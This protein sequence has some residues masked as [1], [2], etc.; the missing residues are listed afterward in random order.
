MPYLVLAYMSC[1]GGC[2][3]EVPLASLFQALFC[4]DSCRRVFLPTTSSTCAS[5]GRSSKSV[6][7]RFP[8]PI[9]NESTPFAP[10]SGLGM[11]RRSDSGAG[12]TQRRTAQHHLHAARAGARR[13]CDWR[14]D[15]TR[16]RHGEEA[17]VD[18]GGPVMLPLLA[19]SLN[20]ASSPD[21]GF[22]GLRRARPWIRRSQ[23]VSEAVNQRAARP[24]QGDDRHRQGRTNAR[25]LSPSL[26]RHFAYGHGRKKT[27]A[28]EARMSPQP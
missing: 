7:K 5:N 22:C 21:A 27:G 13:N 19:E 28:V 17:L 26:A 24:N 25:G 3:H 23:L 16:T 12:G 9:R 4:V 6:C 18:W 2:A 20:G 15:W 1:R 11:R 8:P 14:P 10:V